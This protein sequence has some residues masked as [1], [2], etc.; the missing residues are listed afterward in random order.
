MANRRL[1]SFRWILRTQFGI[2]AGLAAR[3]IYRLPQFVRDLRSFRDPDSPI[4]WKP[5]L[6]DRDSA[7]GSARDEYFW[8]DLFV[9]QK[10]FRAQPSRHID[11]GSRVDGFVAHLASFRTLDVIDIRPLRSD[12]P[13]VQ[14]IQHDMMADDLPP[15]LQADSVSCL[16]ALEHFG[17]GRYGDA[18]D[19]QGYRRGLEN[20][21]RLTA[22]GGTLY[23]SVPIG[24]PRV[25][26]NA[27]RIFDPRSLIKL[28]ASQGMAV[29]EFAVI[30]DG[31][32]PR[33]ALDPLEVAE[34]EAA[35]TYALGVFVLRKWAA[36]DQPAVA[37]VGGA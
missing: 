15:A 28:V 5:C 14:F 10:I 34:R 9:A 19:V 23:L 22:P 7:S 6:H 11:V 30:K 16:H 1:D 24:R 31:A 13:G 35:S 26:F 33:I 37:R 17:L 3:G 25:L 18:L 20:L 21:A 2:D 29:E 8:Q 27:N 12:I 4:E 32:P 36:Q